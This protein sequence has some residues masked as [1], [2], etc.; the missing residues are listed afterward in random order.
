MPPKSDQGFD[1]RRY[2]VIPRTLIFIF[3]GDQVLLLKG[4][5]T[6]KLWANKY[7]G[8]GGHVEGHENI[9]ACARRELLEETGLS[10]IALRPCGSILVDSGAGKGILVFVFEG[11]Y[12]GGRVAASAEGSLHWL[13][14][15]HL[16]TEELV[17]DLTVILPRVVS[18]R[19]GAPFFFARTTY[20]DA[21][22][23]VISFDEP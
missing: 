15:C 1:A 20:N 21:G 6:K 16:P 5:S 22:E 10:G 17:E 4:A 14:G 7:N 3:D 11:D 19:H 8:I 9:A 12:N 18:F 23:M 2:S 13:N